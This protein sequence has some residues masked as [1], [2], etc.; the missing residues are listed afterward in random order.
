MTADRVT[1]DSQGVFGPRFEGGKKKKKPQ[2][3]G[4]RMGNNAGRKTAEAKPDLDLS[5]RGFPG[6][7]ETGSE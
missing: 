6:G 2:A 1:A 3:R 4:T 5:I 7:P